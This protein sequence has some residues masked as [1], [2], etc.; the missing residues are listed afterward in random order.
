MLRLPAGQPLAAPGTRRAR[1]L[2]QRRVLRRRGQ[3]E[4]H[5][6]GGSRC[7][8]GQS[9]TGGGVGGELEGITQFCIE[10]SSAGDAV[11]TPPRAGRGCGR[12]H[13]LT[14]MAQRG[15]DCYGTE[16]SA[17][18]GRRTAP[19]P[20]PGKGHDPAGR[21]G[22]SSA[23]GRVLRRCLDLARARTRQE[24]L[25]DASDHCPHPQ[26]GGRARPGRTQ[27]LQPA[28][29]VF[30]RHWFHLDCPRHLYHFR[31][32]L[33]LTW[34]DE[35]G[36]KVATVRTFS[37]EQNLFGFV[38]SALNVCFGGRRPNAFYHLLRRSPAGPGAAAPTP[39]RLLGLLGYAAIAAAVLPLAVIETV[40]AA[41][42]G[43][44]A[45]LIVY[46]RRADRDSAGGAGG[47]HA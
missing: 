26:A 15:W 12:G 38:Q 18:P 31:K 34:L 45:T 17:F 28:R 33:L 35:N 3:R 14:A 11:R 36:L 47:Q 20:R 9:C 22:G 24:S 16:L 13:L 1:S 23:G 5:A 46:A 43:T 44:G 27:L 2:L 25:D 32:R 39:R 41:V 19:D 21:L 10:H 30:G 42:T 29:I 8:I 40:A 7:P 6:G 37:A 4:V